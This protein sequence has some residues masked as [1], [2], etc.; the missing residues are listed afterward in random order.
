MNADST[1]EDRKDKRDNLKEE[2]TGIGPAYERDLHKIDVMTFAQL[3]EFEDAQQL[4][5]DL[6]RSGSE[7][8]LWKIVNQDWIGQAR[9]KVENQKGLPEVEEAI[10]SKRDQN[11]ALSIKPWKEH[12]AFIVSFDH[13]TD[14]DGEE[15]WRTRVYK[16]ENGYEIEFIG[17]DPSAWTKWIFEQ[18]KLT[19]VETHVEEVVEAEESDLPETEL[20]VTQVPAAESSKQLNL[21]DVQIMSPSKEISQ[22]ELMVRVYFELL[23]SEVEIWAEER[24]S[25]RIELYLLNLERQVTELVASKQSRLEPG[26]LE[27]EI[28]EA[29]PIPAPGRYKLYVLLFSLPPAEM[30]VS[31]PGPIINVVP[32]PVSAQL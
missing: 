25:Y 22:R 24:P 18:A 12:S 9:A 3:A 5:K 17:T 16:A 20:M 30:I 23:G 6:E 13:H 21:V 4:H 10:V 2:I 32:H 31:H 7:I 11:R 8:P 29:I 14:E 26:F 28:D 15:S 19:I 27:Y 1:N